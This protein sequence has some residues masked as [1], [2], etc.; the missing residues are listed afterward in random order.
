MPYQYIANGMTRQYRS[1]RLGPPIFGLDVL[2]SC[3]GQ[4]YCLLALL[5]QLADYVQVFPDFGDESPSITTLL[6]QQ[7]HA[8]PS[9]P[10]APERFLTNQI[11]YI[12]F[13]LVI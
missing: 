1:Q 6:H 4:C 3:L 2:V 11:Q 12:R 9:A 10:Y 7:K 5:G 13:Q 8:A